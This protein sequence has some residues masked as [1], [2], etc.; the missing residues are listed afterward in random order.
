[1][2]QA[3]HKKMNLMVRVVHCTKRRH[4][5]LQKNIEKAAHFGGNGMA[6]AGKRPGKGDHT[7]CKAP[8]RVSAADR[9]FW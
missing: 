1:M 4:A 6:A 5:L 9:G 7:E 2:A 3:F 8:S